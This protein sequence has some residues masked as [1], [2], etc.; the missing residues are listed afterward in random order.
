[1]RSI[2]GVAVRC[3]QTPAVRS[4]GH[5]RFADSRPLIALCAAACVTL[6]GCSGGGS[7]SAGG[8]G[9][10]H[11]VRPSPAGQP[12]AGAAG[13]AAVKATWLKFFNGEVP[14][15]RRLPLLQG[16]QAFAP[17]VSK[18]ETTSLGKLVFS[19]SATVSSVQLGPPGQA[20]V[21]YTILLAGKPLA[22]NLHG[23]AV[24]SGGKWLI[25]TAT[26]CGLATLAFGKHSKSLPPSCAG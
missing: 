12:S 23:T 22:R 6:A 20:A 26:F 13:A 8:A 15:P 21:V 14:I 17:W 3:Q 19:A 1:M 9:H 10:S 24:Y 18:E 5:A 11:S 25:A 4:A 16:Y 2:S 7:P